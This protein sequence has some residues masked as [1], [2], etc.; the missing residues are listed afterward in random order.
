MNN[1]V[2]EPANGFYFSTADTEV[3]SCDKMIIATQNI[4]QSK[5][6]GIKRKYDASFSKNGKKY[7][8][9]KQ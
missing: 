2:I 1:I 4:N 8:N 6:S 3:D 9:K 5:M 7:S